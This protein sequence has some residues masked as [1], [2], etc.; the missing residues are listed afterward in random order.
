[1]FRAK[2]APAPPSPSAVHNISNS[3]IHPTTQ[4]PITAASL[5]YR[6]II[7]LLPQP[8][9]A[10]N[11][12]ESA[13]PQNQISRSA[14]PIES[15]PFFQIAQL[16]SNSAPATPASTTLTKHA[17]H[18]PIRMN[19]STKHHVAPPHTTIVTNSYKALYQK[20]HAARS[21]RFPR[22]DRELGE[23]CVRLRRQERLGTV[24]WA[25]TVLSWM[26]PHCVTLI[27]SHCFKKCASKTFRITLFHHHQGVGSARSASNS[28]YI[29]ANLLHVASVF[30]RN[31][32]RDRDFHFRA[33]SRPAPNLELRPNI[34]GAFLHPQQPP[35]QIALR[36]ERRRIESAA[37]V[38]HHHAQFFRQILHFHFNAFRSGM[39]HR[40]GQRFPRDQIN[41]MLDRRRQRPRLSH[42]HS[43]K[44]RPARRELPAEITEHFF[45]PRGR[46]HRRT[47]PLQH[48]AALVNHAVHHPQNAIQ[49][50]FTRRIRRRLFHCHIEQHRRSEKPLEQRVVQ[51][52]RNVRALLKAL[53]QADGLFALAAFPV[54]GREPF[55]NL[56][57]H[58]HHHLAAPRCSRAQRIQRSIKILVHG[59][60]PPVSIHSRTN[61]GQLI[62]LI[63]RAVQSAKN[64]TTSLSTSRTSRKSRVISVPAASPSSSACNSNRCW[65]S[66]RPL[67][68]KQ[69]APPSSDLR[70]R[71]ICA[72][73]AR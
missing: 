35:V 6:F 72:R 28:F 12:L 37:I 58:A 27:E 30:R 73:G 40:I 43:A 39:P 4:P 41:L 71:N 68:A 7:S 3:A 61:D 5:T 59:V 1:M 15:T 13:L 53:F 65:S 9:S 49:R 21:Y 54:E 67:R 52:P 48:P 22:L 56:A 11:P 25:A 24:R 10:L 57:A 17:P 55:L 50:R 46:I 60:Y 26:N 66:I 2:S 70:I 34:R 69:M 45:Q 47:Q 33:R 29:N 63:P 38:S 44:L 19:T 18:N 32:A 14:N 51:F 62:S 42:N 8:L 64:L 16:R 20:M 23:G 36:L 31:V